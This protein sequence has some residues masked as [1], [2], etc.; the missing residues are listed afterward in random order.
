MRVTP[1]AIGWLQ[2][3]LQHEFAAARQFTLQAAV[4]GHGGSRQLAAFCADAAVDELAHARRLAD[5]LAAAGAALGSGGGPAFPV[6]T[7][8]SE[9][10]DHGIATE[11]A[12]VVLYAQAARACAAL[13]SLAALFAAIGDDE[14]RHLAQLRQQRAALATAPDRPA[15]GNGRRAAAGGPAARQP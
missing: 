5:V 6:G 4:A 15:A 10:L 9:I 3:A 1:Q 14:A 7:Q 12:A 2:R 13:P 11:Q 8:A